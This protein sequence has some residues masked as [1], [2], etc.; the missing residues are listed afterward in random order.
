MR[1][2]QEIELN[3]RVQVKY[4]KYIKKFSEG[5]SIPEQK[6]IHHSVFGILSSKSCILRRMSQGLKERISLKKTSKRLSYHLP[7]ED[8]G[9]QLSDRV[10]R[11]QAGRVDKETIIIG[12]PGDIVKKYAR[13]MEGLSSVRDGSTG[14]SGTGYNVL[15]VIAVQEGLDGALKIKPMV[16]DLYSSAMDEESFKTRFFDRVNDLQIYSNN[17]GIYTLD[18]GYDDKKVIAYLHHHNACFIIRSQGVRDLYYKGKRMS[19]S[20]VAKQVKVSY[21]Y[22]GGGKRLLAGAVKVCIPVDPHPRKKHP[23]LVPVTLIVARYKGRKKLGGFFSLFCSFP[24]TDMLEEALIGKALRCYRIRWKI[25]EVY[26]HIKVD[27]KWESM[28]L[29]KYQSLKTL[30][31]L[32]LAALVFLYDLES[33]KLSFAQTYTAL[34]LES[35]NKLKYLSKFIYYRISK[36]ISYCFQ[37]MKIYRKILY[38][39]PQSLQLQLELI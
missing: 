23:T 24:H 32:F 12:D 8:L 39:N 3:K 19:F 4:Q 22:D 16:S 1:N 30:N 33:M 18:R 11:F 2:I 31:A 26:R 21:E 10:L 5:F 27:F 28:R 6:F 38:K 35:K 36:V 17:K 34:M 15:D 9:S 20:D 25:E 13:K 29:M 37:F 14:V 7:K